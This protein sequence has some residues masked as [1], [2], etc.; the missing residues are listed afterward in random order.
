MMIKRCFA[1]ALVLSLLATSPLMA[2]E[3]WTDLGIYLF[4]L[5]IEGDAQIR[6]VSADVDVGFDDIVD[7]L[8]FA[9]MGYLEHRRGKWSFIGDLVYLRLEDDESTAF[10][11]RILSLEVELDAEVEQYT[12]EGFVGYRVFEREYDTANL[13]LDLLVGARYTELD[14]DLSSE[15]TLLGPNLSL[16]RENDRARNED[17]TD[18]VLALRLQYGGDKGWGSSFWVD[19]GDG[20][21]S[22]SEQF[23]ALASYRGNSNWR[24][25][26]GYRFVNLEYETGSGASTFDIDLDY[27]GPLFA[28]SYRM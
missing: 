7:N 10:D 12:F 18:T 17:W 15:A 8:D 6:N 2:E 19:V 14:I 26:G 21:D 25:I 4:A 23:M 9:Y 16:S 24:F 27:S 22:S 3:T 20:S 11:R 1:L 28:A 5:E 13:G